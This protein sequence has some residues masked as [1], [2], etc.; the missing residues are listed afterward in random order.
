MNRFSISNVTVRNDLIYLERKGVLKRKYG[1]AILY[2]NRYQSTFDINNIKN[3]EEKEKIG[4]YA[5]AMIRENDS[6]MLYT[7]TTTLQIARFIDPDLNFVGVTNSM[8]IALEL[9]HRARNAR[10]VIIG[11]N[12]NKK[13]GSTYGDDAIK[14]LEAY[15]IDTLFLAVDGISVGRGITNA[16]PYETD[17]NRALIHKANKVIVVTDHTK[18]GAVSF[19]NMGNIEEVDMLITDSKANKEQVELIMNSGVK[20]ITV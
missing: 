7:G 15:N 3:L 14:Q 18:I 5:S 1:K 20:V 4:K 12:L 16:D 6:V 9:R 2:E 11:G 17:I 19:V 13:T 10:L 8:F